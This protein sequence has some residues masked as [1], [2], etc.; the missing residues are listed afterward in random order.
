MNEYTLIV[1]GILCLLFGVGACVYMYR[2]G[3]KHGKATVVPFPLYEE[4]LDHRID[5]L[6]QDPTKARVEVESTL[7]TAGWEA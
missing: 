4:L 6:G 5:C 7:D 2:L 3:V 1:F